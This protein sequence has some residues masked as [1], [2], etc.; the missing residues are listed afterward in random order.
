MHIW[1]DWIREKLR[2]AVKKVKA[3]YNAEKRRSGVSGWK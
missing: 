1:D 3:S 2:L